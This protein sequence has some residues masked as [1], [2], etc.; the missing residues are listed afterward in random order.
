MKPE[1][2]ARVIGSVEQI[3]NSDTCLSSEMVG[4]LMEEDAVFRV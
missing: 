4:K 1:A 2:S 3:G